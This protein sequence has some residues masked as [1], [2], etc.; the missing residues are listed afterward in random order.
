MPRDSGKNR[1]DSI[2]DAASYFKNVYEGLPEQVIKDV[3]EFC[4]KNPDRFPNG[5]ESINIKKVPLP[6]KP[7]EKTIEGAVEIVDNPEDPSMKILKHKEG[8]T[9]LTAEEADE[10]QLKINE[11]L[12]KQKEEELDDFRRKY[13]EI[14]KD[15]NKTK[16]RQKIRDKRH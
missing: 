3:I 4:M 1:F 8:A 15:L 13:H 11:A 12:E 10:L 6:K 16:L 7:V 5:C 2:D 14:N 9:L